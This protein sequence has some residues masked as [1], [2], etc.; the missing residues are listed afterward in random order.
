MNSL[1]AQ[2]QAQQIEAMATQDLF[3]RMTGTC[4]TKCVRRYDDG[5]VT[6]GEGESSKH[7]RVTFFF[8]ADD[9]F[10][11]VAQ[12]KKNN[13]LLKGACVERCVNKYLDTYR[14]VNEHMMAKNQQEQQQQLQM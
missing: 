7:I 3:K 4:F 12:E 5:E 2:K 8:F 6:V 1:N 9:C 10:V 13:F 11:C 14:I